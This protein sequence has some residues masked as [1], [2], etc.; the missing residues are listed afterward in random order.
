MIEFL[1]GALI[2]FVVGYTFG[3]LINSLDKKNDRE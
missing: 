1:L 3:L 2:G